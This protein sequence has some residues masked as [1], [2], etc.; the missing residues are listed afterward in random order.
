LQ[1]WGTVTAIT[2][3]GLN[4]LA[5]DTLV[6]MAEVADGD[7]KV[8]PQ[9]KFWIQFKVGTSPA[10]NSLVSAF[11]ARGDDHGTEIYDGLQEAALYEAG[12]EFL[13]AL[14]VASNNDYTYK[15]S[16]TADNPGTRWKL[17]IKNDTNAALYGS[18]HLIH[19]RYM[20]PEVQ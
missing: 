16:V 8:P 15:F 14:P 10:A 3:T 12:L 6:A 1:S 19:Y 5:D 9:I 20:T 18:G 11:L 2:A 13:G 17:V 4:S 7:E